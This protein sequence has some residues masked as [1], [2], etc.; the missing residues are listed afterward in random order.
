MT[1]WVLPLLAGTATGVLS[2]FGVGGG[3]LLLVWLTAFAGLPQEQA[4]GIN[5]LY[6]LP[7]AGAALPAHAK[8]GYLEKG[9][10]LPA[11]AA[12]L[13]CAGLGAWAATGLDAGL[14]RRCFGGFL[15]AVGLRELF[16]RG[17]TSAGGRP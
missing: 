8:N 6:F 3:S 11:I 15:L 7:A 5:L 10:L 1:G 2:G 9:V 13:A 12:G 16:R 17:E 4:Q 14:L